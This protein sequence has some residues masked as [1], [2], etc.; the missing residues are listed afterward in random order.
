MHPTIDLNA[1]LGEGFGHSRSSEDEALLDLVTSANIACGFHAGDATTMR[2]TVRAAASRGIVIGAHPSYPDIPGFGRRELGLS[3]KEIRFHVSRQ[4][5][6]FSDVCRGENAK[7]SYVK[8]HGAL[9]NRAAKDSSAAIAI[10][11]AIRELDPSLILLGLAGSEMA[12]AAARSGLAFAG[13]AFADRAYKSDGS[14]VPRT[15]PGAVINDV[16]TAVKRAI[17][18]VR[19]STVTADD[20]T[21]LGV[22]AQSLCV[23][24]DNPD[25]LP[26]LRELR[27]NLERSGVRIAPFAA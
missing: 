1:D 7:L 8:P 2:D 3:P 13:E 18:L 19:S 24:G 22:V 26:M 20:G 9:Y 23:H 25:A 16:Q 6:S 17:T 15:E 21:T 27:T 12:R 11:E 10:V 14:L 4:L 5:R